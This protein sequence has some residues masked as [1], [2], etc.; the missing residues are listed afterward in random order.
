M[1]LQNLGK[2]FVLIL[3]S[4]GILTCKPKYTTQPI[5]NF[6]CLAE[7]DA[8]ISIR[9]TDR[10]Q[11]VWQ[12]LKL[13]ICHYINYNLTNGQCELGLGQCVSLLPSW[14]VMV[15]TYGPLRYNCLQWGSMNVPGRI[16]VKVPDWG[17][18]CVARI[19]SGDSLLVGK[20]TLFNGAFWTNND[21]V[22]VGPISET[23][24]DIEIL[25]MD[26]TCNA[27]WMS[28][29]AGESLPVGAVAGG[30]LADGS[31]TYVAKV[32]HDGRQAL[33]Y[34]NPVSATAYYTAGGYYTATSMDI[35]VLL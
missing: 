25:T 14:G 30:H 35:F 29:T 11:C 13:N 28:Y 32:T 3:Q 18:L 4:T 16:P 26:A 15:N 6:R 22:P 5:F 34:Y 19:V 17:G 24:Q 33:G 23:D 21:G 31:P 20:V 27:P 9:Q 8:D 12:C 1:E 7:P 2:L 10:A